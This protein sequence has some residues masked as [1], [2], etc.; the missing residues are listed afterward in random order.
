[1]APQSNEMLKYGTILPYKGSTSS[2]GK[3]VR[4]FRLLLADDHF[5]VREGIRRLLEAEFEVVRAVGEGGALLQ[6][7]PEL[8]VDAVVSD[9]PMPNV[10]GIRAG[11]RIVSRPAA[12]HAGLSL[13]DARVAVT[14]QER[15]SQPVTPYSFNFA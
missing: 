5:E 14:G 15:A 8:Q 7:A 2:S 4:R 11:A 13:N 12:R 10:D 6:A 9:V 1:M 3:A